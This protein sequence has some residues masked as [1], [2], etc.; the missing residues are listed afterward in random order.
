MN[1]RTQ[2]APTSELHPTPTDPSA[3]HHR[4]RHLRMPSSMLS[5]GDK[6]LREAMHRRFLTV[7]LVLALGAGVVALAFDLTSWAAWVVLVAIC[8][9]VIGVIIAISPTRRA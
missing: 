4:K 3:S 7:L 5:H 1:R 2:P 9:T 8:A 6:L